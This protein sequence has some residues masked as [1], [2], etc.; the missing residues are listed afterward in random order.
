MNQSECRPSCRAALCEACGA[1]PD[2]EEEK[3]DIYRIGICRECLEKDDQ[4]E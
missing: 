4:I 1:M 2:D 3:R